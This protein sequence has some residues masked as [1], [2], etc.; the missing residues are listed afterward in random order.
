LLL[1]LSPPF[2]KVL[3]I[4]DSRGFNRSTPSTTGHLKLTPLSP[5]FNFYFDTFSAFLAFINVGLIHF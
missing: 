4:I 5:Y 3:T 2:L 1:L